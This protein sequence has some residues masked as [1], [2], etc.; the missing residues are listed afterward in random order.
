MKHRVFDELCG[1]IA[2]A[3]IVALAVVLTGLVADTAA[4]SFSEYGSPTDLVEVLLR[5]ATWVIAAHVIVRARQRH[6]ISLAGC[7]AS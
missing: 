3:F 7:R 6:R 1:V 2:K 5:I 4:L